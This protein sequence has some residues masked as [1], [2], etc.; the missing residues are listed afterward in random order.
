MKKIIAMLLALVMA[1]SMAACAGEPAPATEAPT[2][3]PAAQTPAETE[4]PATEAPAETE[5]PAASFEVEIPE[6]DV[7]SY[8]DYVAAELDTLVTIEAYVQAK[9]SWWQDKA[10]L[11][12]QDADG[13]YYIYEIPCSQEDYNAM[14]IGSKLRV[15]GYKAEFSGEVEIDGSSANFQFVDS[16]PWTATALDITEMLGEDLTAY[17]NQLIFVKE[18]TVVAANDAGDAFMYGWDGSGQE[19]SDSDLYFKVAVG[20]NTMTFVV[21]Y[22]LCDAEGNYGDY[23][24]FYKTVQGLKVGDQLDITA[25]LYWYEGPQPHVCGIMQVG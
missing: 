18:A 11:H 21:E 9:C 24:D 5:A 7:I 15:S 13:A 16:E 25:F 23:T 8:A 14:T 12:L 19:G 3:A 10:S 2:E 1:L 4:A 17:Q 20:E 6:A 22:Y